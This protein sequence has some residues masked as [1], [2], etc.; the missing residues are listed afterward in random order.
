MR[1]PESR[2]TARKTRRDG[3]TATR[4]LGF[5]DALVGT[6]SVTRAA[7]SV[8]MSRESAYRLRARDQGGLF[9]AL[10]DRVAQLQSAPSEGHSHRLSDGRLLRALGTHFRRERGDFS[11][12]RS[13]PADVQHK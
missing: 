1:Q 4:Q 11:A 10:W 6:R 2:C 12:L 7:A 9:A 3:W 8:G 5:L 13:S